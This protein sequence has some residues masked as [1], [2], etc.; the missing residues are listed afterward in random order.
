M[1]SFGGPTLDIETVHYLLAV[2]N[3]TDLERKKLTD[4]KPGSYAERHSPDCA[5]SNALSNCPT[6]VSVPSEIKQDSRS[7]F[8][9]KAGKATFPSKGRHS[10]SDEA[11]QFKTDVARFRL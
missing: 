3:L 9:V 6:R 11:L 2:P 1:L 10:T 7:C 5:E 4:T 8:F